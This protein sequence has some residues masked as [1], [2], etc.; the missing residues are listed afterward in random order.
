MIKRIFY[1]LLPLAFALSCGEKEGPD[2][3]GGSGI[4][5]AV[6]DNPTGPYTY[7]PDYVDQESKACEAPNCWKRIGTDTYVL[8]YDCFGIVPPNFGFLETTDFKTYTNIGHFNEEGGKMKAVNFD[9]PKHGAVTYITQ[10]Q[11]RQLLRYWQEH[12]NHTAKSIQVIEDKKQHTAKA[13][14]K[15]LYR[16]PIYDG[17]ADP[18]LIYNKERKAWW[19]FYTNRRANMEGGR[20]VEWVHGTPIGIAESK[21]GATW[22]YVGDA[23]INYGKEKGYTYWAPDV[24]EANGKYHMFL[25]VVPGIFADWKHPREIVHLTSKNLKDWKFE[26]RLEL[27]SDRVI[28]A[29]LI[30]APDGRWLMF[31]NN[32]ADKKSICMAESRDLKHWTDHGKIIGDKRGEG[33]NVFRWHNK[34]FMIVDNWD[35]QGVYSSDDLKTWTRQKDEILSAPGKGADDGINGNHAEVVVNG[36]RAYIFYFTH[37]G[38]AGGNKADNYATRRSTIQVAELQEK[39]G[40]ISCDRDK[41]VYINLNSRKQ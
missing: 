39:D 26:D 31:Y 35:G 10:E 12:P 32:E 25:T 33:P 24:V 23:N 3:G 15:P 34:Y 18:T 14:A 1:F 36:D 8:M 17:A 28:D 13:A 30:Q 5:L 21:D 20:G 37:P 2:D 9:K 40:I 16:D 38:R 22:R 29:D 11:A 4:K 19:M 27:A 41:T 7:L 6:A